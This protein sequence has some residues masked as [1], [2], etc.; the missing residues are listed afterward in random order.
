MTSNNIE[1]KSLWNQIINEK[2]INFFIELEHVFFILEKLQPMQ[3]DISYHYESFLYKGISIKVP[4]EVY[5]K[6]CILRFEQTNIE[7]E[8][9]YFANCAMRAFNKTKFKKLRDIYNDKNETL[10]KYFV[11]NYR[12]KYDTLYGE[13]NASNM[14]NNLKEKMSSLDEDIILKRNEAIR[15]AMLDCWHRRKTS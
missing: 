12:A 4:I 2:N 9:Y 15:V 3:P 8:K 11:K 13:E 1:E 10:K 6:L 14:K 5:Y 7:D